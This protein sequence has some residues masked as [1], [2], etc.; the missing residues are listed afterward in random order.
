[1][2]MYMYT[3]ARACTYTYICK[4]KCGNLETRGN[5]NRKS[6]KVEAPERR[7]SMFLFLRIQESIF[8]LR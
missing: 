4:S 3:D 6:S 1:M 2:Y 7:Q 5:E 8:R